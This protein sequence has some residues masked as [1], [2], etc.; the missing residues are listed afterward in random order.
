[1]S[2]ILEELGIKFLYNIKYIFESSHRLISKLSMVIF[3]T[4]GFNSRDVTSV[5]EFLKWTFAV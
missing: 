5:C 4:A 2:N 3:F 1:M